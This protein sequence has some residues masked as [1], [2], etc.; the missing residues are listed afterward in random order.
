ML[1]QPIAKGVVAVGVGVYQRADLGP[2]VAGG[3]LH[4]AQH[5]HR[6]PLI[7]QRVDEQRLIAAAQKPALLKPHE[8]SGCRY[9]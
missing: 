6:K 4:G 7:K 8:P 5:L 1:D 9:A 3:G 2:A